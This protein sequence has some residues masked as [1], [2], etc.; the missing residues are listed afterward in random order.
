MRRFDEKELIRETK[1]RLYRLPQLLFRIK[2]SKAE[3]AELKSSGFDMSK[4]RR[5]SKSFVSLIKS[6]MRLSPMDAHLAQIEL[7]EQRISADTNEIHQLM[8]ALKCVKGDRYY[9]AICYKFFKNLDDEEVARR[10]K[11]TPPTLRRNRARLLHQIA[12]ILYG[13]QTNFY[14]KCNM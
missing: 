6:G 4:L 12:N 13:M 10:L 11:C 5:N 8:R 14:S 9:N 3:L 7:L 1:K 2:Y